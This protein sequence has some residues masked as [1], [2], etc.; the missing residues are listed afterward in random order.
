[1]RTNCCQ[2]IREIF[3]VGW[4]LKAESAGLY[5]LTIARFDFLYAEMMRVQNYQDEFESSVRKESDII[6]NLYFLKFSIVA[7]YIH[8]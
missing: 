2:K 7:I 5:N 1:M 6:R 3:L 4:F 8:A